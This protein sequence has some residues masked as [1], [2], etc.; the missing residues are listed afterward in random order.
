MVQPMGNVT[1]T[2]AMPTVPGGV[3]Q[4]IC[5]P[6]VES[7]VAGAPPIVTEEPTTK[8]VPRM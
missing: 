7:T 4:M 5:E 2:G 3:R 8:L 1:T 6:V